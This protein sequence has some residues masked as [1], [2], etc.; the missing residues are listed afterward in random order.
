MTDKVTSVPCKQCGGSGFRQPTGQPCDMC[1][2][3]GEVRIVEENEQPYRPPV[4]K[5]D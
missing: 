3:P 5:T 2:G 1:G 4:R